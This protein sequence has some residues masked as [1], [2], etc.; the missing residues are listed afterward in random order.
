[1]ELTR[2]GAG[3][4]LRSCV[5]LIAACVAVLI[6]AVTAASAGAAARGVV[7]QQ[8]ESVYGVSPSSIPAIAAELGPAGLGSSYTRVSVHWGRFQPTAPDAAGVDTYDPEYLAELDAVIAA[9][10]AQHIRVILTCTDVPEWASDQRYWVDHTYD[11]DIAARMDD[12]VVR[13]AWQRLGGFLAAR[14]KGRADYFEVWNEPNLGSGIYPQLVGK[15]KTPVGPST[16]VKMLKAFS[17]GVHSANSQAVVIAGAT[18]RRGANDVHSTSPQWF[19]SYLKSH[20]AAR[21]FQAYSHHPYTPPRYDPRPDAKPRRPTH[22]VTLGN[23]STLL[24]IFPTK[25]FYL[26]E[27]G[28]S[29]GKNDLFCVTVSAA[30]QAQYLN[31]AYAL[32]ARYRQVKVMLWYLLTDWVDPSQA[33]KGIFSG[34]QKEDGTLKPAWFA[35]ARSNQISVTTPSSAVP[36][37]TFPVQGAL[38]TKTGPRAGETLLL[39]A[40]ASGQKGWARVGSAKTLADGTYAFN[41]SQKQTRSYRVVWDGVCQS[42]ARKVATP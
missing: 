30:K 39:Q 36:K 11:S 9:L 33:P 21:Y 19:A 24:K 23:L 28:L 1:V 34:L 17:A 42:A 16:Y 6:L 13:N 41:V 32:V 4:R 25:P 31:E 26:T 3:T 15:K 22:E 38:T 20:G 5:V 37:A 14:Y 29:T 7:D 35:F 12:P 18:S 27:Y 2:T 40:R 8:I 10:S